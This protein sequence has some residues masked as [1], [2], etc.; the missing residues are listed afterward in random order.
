MMHS[1]VTAEEVFLQI[2]KTHPNISRATVYRNLNIL[3]EEGKIGRISI[4]DKAAKFDFI[5]G[6]HYHVRCEKCEKLFDVD[7]NGLD[8]VEEELKTKIRNDNGF[9]FTGCDIIFKGI[10]PECKNKARI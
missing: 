10:C 3:F 5:S 1:H 7:M 9:T 2:Q 8:S 6:N 4:P